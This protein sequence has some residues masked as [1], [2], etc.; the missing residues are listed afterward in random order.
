MAIM[1][2]S[3]EGKRFKPSDKK[4][5]A[6]T[7]HQVQQDIVKSSYK[8]RFPSIRLSIF[9]M[10][11]G[12]DLL[13]VRISKFLLKM[14]DDGGN[15]SKMKA[16]A[17]LEVDSFNRRKVKH[18]PFLEPWQFICCRE[19]KN[20]SSTFEIRNAE[21]LSFQRNERI[22]NQLHHN[23]LNINL[24]TECIETL[25]EI[26]KLFSGDMRED[27]PYCVINRTTKSIRIRNSKEGTECPLIDKDKRH[28]LNWRFFNIS[29]RKLKYA[30]ES[31]NNAYIDVEIIEDQGSKAQQAN[32]EAS[33]PE[34][35]ASPYS[36]AHIKKAESALV[37]TND[38]PFESQC[39]KQIL[40]DRLGK[41][42]YKIREVGSSSKGNKRGLVISS[43]CKEQES[44][45]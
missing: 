12:I 31:T 44:C 8:F 28:P 34:E 45:E 1:T 37:K 5:N 6:A 9:K 19:S 35:R 32:K 11:Q 42:V 39:I 7:A 20:N 4:E 3:F 13:R 29:I 15:R 23:S 10:M 18:E 40:C 2:P 24:S 26:S 36:G 22:E 25:L 41:T 27:N 33:N 21:D 38:N 14:K 16:R 43:S 30:I 17:T